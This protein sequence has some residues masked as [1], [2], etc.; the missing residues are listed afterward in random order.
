MMCKSYTDKEMIMNALAGFFGRNLKGRIKSL[1]W[2]NT[3]NPLLGGISP[4]HMVHAGRGI[5]LLR[6]I[7]QQ[8]A[9]NLGPK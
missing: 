8:I 2:Y 5:K 6:F 7:D 1:S 3:N 9:D 4:R